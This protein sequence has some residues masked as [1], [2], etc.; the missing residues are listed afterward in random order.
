MNDNRNWKPV[1][2]ILHIKWGKLSSDD[3]VSLS[4]RQRENDRKRALPFRI[5]VVDGNEPLRCDFDNVIITN[6]NRSRIRDGL[7]LDCEGAEENDE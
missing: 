5:E 3:P 7:C 4:D 2:E 6:E 1:D